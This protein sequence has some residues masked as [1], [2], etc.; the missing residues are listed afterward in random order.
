MFPEV[1]FGLPSLPSEPVVSEAMTKIL[2]AWRSRIKST[3]AVDRPEITPSLFAGYNDIISRIEDLARIVLS[4]GIVEKEEIE[5][6]KK[7]LD[8][9]TIDPLILFSEKVKARMGDAPGL[10]PILLRNHMRQEQ[11]AGFMDVS[12]SF[13]YEVENL[14]DSAEHFH[15]VEDTLQQTME[16]FDAVCYDRGTGDP[17]LGSDLLVQIP[18]GLLLMQQFAREVRGSLA[19]AYTTELHDQWELNVK[20]LIEDWAEAVEK[21]LKGELNVVGDLLKQDKN[22]AAI[23]L[24]ALK[25]QLIKI[26]ENIAR[27]MPAFP[28]ITFNSLVTLKT[29]VL[30]VAVARID[31]LTKLPK[32]NA[33]TIIPLGLSEN[34]PP[35]YGDDQ[36]KALVG[37]RPS[38]REGV[39]SNIKSFFSRLIPE[40]WKRS[41]ERTEQITRIALFSLMLSGDI[42]KMLTQIHGFHCY[43]DAVAKELQKREFASVPIDTVD[44]IDKEVRYI[45]NMAGRH[46]KQFGNRLLTR[47]PKA[48][49]LLTKLRYDIGTNPL[50]IQKADE[51]AEFHRLTR[52][53]HELPRS[54][55]Y[56][57]LEFPEWWSA[58][59]TDQETKVT[60]P[61]E[62]PFAKTHEMVN[63]TKADVAAGYWDVSAEAEPIIAGLGN[64][65]P[66]AHALR[67]G[68]YLPIQALRQEATEQL[69]LAEL[70]F[71]IEHSSI[72]IDA[73]TLLHIG[74]DLFGEKSTLEGHNPIRITP[75]LVDQVMG[76]LAALT[77]TGRC[78]DDSKALFCDQLFASQFAASREAKLSFF[79]SLETKLSIATELNIKLQGASAKEFCDAIK[80]QLEALKPEDPTFFSG[81]WKKHAIVYEIIKHNNG[82]MTFRFY[83]TGE[84]VNYFARTV[85]KGE[86]LYEPYIEIN[87]IPEEN[88]SNPIFWKALYELENGEF[89][90]PAYILANSILPSLGGTLY[91]GVISVEK[92]REAQRS[93]TCSYQ[94]L[95]SAVADKQP[96]APEAQHDIFVTE[97]KAL[98]DFNQQNKINYTKLSFDD[99]VNFNLVSKYA[100]AFAARLVEWTDKGHITPREQKYALNIV[101]G[102]QE[103]L[104]AALDKIKADE[105]V[106]SPLCDLTPDLL[107]SQYNGFPLSTRYLTPIASEKNTIS[108]ENAL[109]LAVQQWTPRGSALM[110]DMQQFLE[111]ISKKVGRDIQ[112]FQTRPSSKIS[113]QE[114]VNVHAGIKQIVLKIPLHETAFWGDLKAED[115]V[116]LMQAFRDLGQRFSD[117]LADLRRT[118]PNRAVELQPSDYLAVVKL[119][120]VA[121]KLSSEH[122]VALGF[123]HLNLYQKR[124]ETF[125]HAGSLF[126]SVADPSWAIEAS[127]LR[128]YWQAARPKDGSDGF[129]QLSAKPMS[130]CDYTPVLIGKIE[131]AL[132]CD[133]REFTWILEQLQKS[134]IQG[135]INEKY[136]GSSFAQKSILEQAIE[137]YTGLYI[138][139]PRKNFKTIIP[140]SFRQVVELSYLADTLPA[141]DFG[142][143]ST[144]E[145][146]LFQRSV[147]SLGTAL[148]RYLNKSPNIP[149][150]GSR[151]DSPPWDEAYFRRT[152]PKIGMNV[153]SFFT[154]ALEYPGVV[155]RRVLPPNQVVVATPDTLMLPIGAQK[156]LDVQG[157]QQRLGMNSVMSLQIEETLGFFVENPSLL[158]IADN[159]LLFK[160]FFLDAGLLID[161]MRTPERL[162]TF[163]ACFNQFCNHHYR[164]N[165]DI[166]RYDIALFYLEISQLLCHSLE[167]WQKYSQKNFEV[168]DIATKGFLHIDKECQALSASKSLLKFAPNQRRQLEYQ[169]HRLLVHHYAAIEPMTEDSLT[170]LL[171]QKIHLSLYYDDEMPPEAAVDLRTRDVLQTRLETIQTLLHKPQQRNFILNAVWNHFSP[172]SPVIEWTQDGFPDFSSADKRNFIH[173]AEGTITSFDS[174]VSLIPP[175]IANH[176]EFK[177]HFLSLVQIPEETLKRFFPE[178][179]Q[180]RFYIEHLKG[181]RI[182]NAIRIGRDSFEFADEAHNRYRVKK[183]GEG[184]IFERQFSQEWCRQSLDRDEGFS[185]FFVDEKTMI[186]KAPNRNEKGEYVYY[187]TDKLTRVPQYEV[188]MQKNKW[189]DRIDFTVIHQ[190]DPSSQRTGL[191]VAN[192][193]KC[194]FASSLG[195]F[196]NPAHIIVLQELAT[197]VIKSLEFPRYGLSFK[198][199]KDPETKQWVAESPQYPGYAVAEVQRVPALRELDHYLVLKK[200]PAEGVLTRLVLIPDVPFKTFDPEKDSTLEPIQNIHEASRQGT[201]IEGLTFRDITPVYDYAVDPSTGQLNP[202]KNVEAGRLVLALNSLWK[203]KYGAAARQLDRIPLIRPLTKKEGVLLL[204]IVQMHMANNDPDLESHAVRLKALALFLRSAPPDLRATLNQDEDFTKNT[205]ASYFFYANTSRK[206]LGEKQ[207]L[208]MP[209][210]EIGLLHWL[211]KQAKNREL[212]FKFSNTQ[213]EVLSYRKQLLGMQ[214]NKEW[215]APP[216]TQGPTERSQIIRSFKNAWTRDDFKVS[217]RDS[218]LSSEI[219]DLEA[220]YAAFRNF[221]SLRE[222]EIHNIIYQISGVSIDWQTMPRERLVETLRSVLMM[223]FN[224]HPNPHDVSPPILILLGLIEDASR[225][226]SAKAFSY[227][228]QEN[229]AHLDEHNLINSLAEA[230]ADVVTGK[231]GKF[232]PLPWDTEPSVLEMGLQATSVQAPVAG[233]CI[234]LR[235]L[236]FDQRFPFVRTHDLDRYFD[237]G[238]VVDVVPSTTTATELLAV[239]QPATTVDRITARELK[240]VRDLVSK[241][242]P[243]SIEPKYTVKELGIPLRDFRFKLGDDIAFESGELMAKGAK[244]LEMANQLPAD[245]QAATDLQTRWAADLKS[246]IDLD[247]LFRLFLRGDT[248]GYQQRNPALT[249]DK[250]AALANEVKAYLEQATYRQHLVRLS[251]SVAALETEMAHGVP[252][253]ELQPRIQEVRTLALTRRHFSVKVH[254]EYLVFEYYMNLLMRKSQVENL[255]KL[256]IKDGKI[257]AAQYLGAVL[258]MDMGGGKT[259]VLLPLLGLLHADGKH[260]AIGVLPDALIPSMSSELYMTSKGSFDQALEVL[261]FDRDVDLNAESLELLRQQLVHIQKDRK[262][263]L[264]GSGSVQSLYLKWIE[265]TELYTAHTRKIASA[266][267]IG[268]IVLKDTYKVQVEQELKLFREIFAL[269][270]KA[271]I[272]MIDEVDTVLNVLKS[273]HYTIGEAKG[274]EKLFADVISDVYAFLADSEDINQNISLGFTHFT[275]EKPFTK[276]QHDSI[277][278]PALVDALFEGKLGRKIVG[279]PEFMATMNQD[280]NKAQKESVTA[281]L[282]GN[283]SKD[284]DDFIR[285]KVAPDI[286]DALT[287]YRQEISELLPL[288]LSRNLNE[289]YGRDPVRPSSYLALPYD[290]STPSLRAQFGTEMEETNYAMQ[291]NWADFPQDIVR[292]ELNHLADLVN[293]ERRRKPGIDFKTLLIYKKNFLEELAGGDPSYDLFNVTPEQLKTMTERVDANS[294][295]KMKLINRYVL[296]Q[297]RVYERQLNAD[298]QIFRLLFHITMGMTGTTQNLD[299]FP[300]EMR[301]NFH[302]SDTTEKSLDILWRMSSKDPCQTL[303]TPKSP[304]QDSQYVTELVNSIFGNKKS[305]ARSIIDT[306]GLFRDV[307]DRAD[308]AEAMLHALQSDP[309]IQGVAFY[310][311]SN[312]LMVMTLIDGKR[313]VV[314]LS[315]SSLKRQQIAA[316]WDQQHT[317]GSDIRVSLTMCA[318]VTIGRY[319]TLRDLLQS[320]WRLRGLATGQRVEFVVSQEERDLI[321]DVLKKKMGISIGEDENLKF[322]HI[323]LYSINTG[324]ERQGTDNYRAF[325]QKL[326]AYLLEK[327]LTVM[328]D[329][330]TPI[331]KLGEFYHAAEALFATTH[332]IRPYFLYGARKEPL[333]RE[334]ALK[335]D[336]DAFI[337]SPA[338]QLFATDPLLSE[339]FSTKALK[340]GLDALGKE[341]L[342]R[343]PEEVVKSAYGLEQEKEAEKE[344]ETKTEKEDVRSVF[345][346][347][348]GRPRPVIVWERNGLFTEAYFNLTRVDSILRRDYEIKART[349]LH[350]IVGLSDVLNHYDGL[351]EFKDVF[352]S[353]LTC[354][355]NMCPV[356]SSDIDVRAYEPFGYYQQQLSYVLAKE[357]K[358]GL[359]LMLLDQNDADAFKHMLENDSIAPLKG[360]AKEVRLKLYHLSTGV[361]TQGQESL[362]PQAE[363]E[364]NKLAV[365]AKFFRGVSRYEGKEKEYLEQWVKAHGVEKMHQ[366]FTEKVLLWN[367]VSQFY[368]YNSPL[369]NILEPSTESTP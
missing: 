331:E 17:L 361:T 163:V 6:L 124:F 173:I 79:E 234:Y 250:A 192:M 2:G 68:Q 19:E 98:Y 47:Y 117:N 262:V 217:A 22:G 89:K 324:A 368:Y 151:Y 104:R 333:K 14:V 299:T 42:S 314:D 300:K 276:E 142:K 223:K 341:E 96:S 128:R 249:P 277:V 130:T 50:S 268:E 180:R 175:S 141:S 177:H 266:A 275:A 58:F 77:K 251:E 355:L 15:L 196:E 27:N 7:E 284:D 48:E 194:P 188:T 193:K 247:E 346:P 134:D 232:A 126:F 70:T 318:A 23:Q 198:V 303:K 281:F 3:Y 229:L 133:V 146:T 257:G 307:K 236:P 129:F 336:I 334:E 291:L 101:Q 145:Y 144:T 139:S 367:K 165:I 100:E 154:G 364:F 208:F 252:N 13:L 112:T 85:V 293:E 122:A 213:L 255:N 256:E 274:L 295:V 328:L 121:D 327:L 135:V 190:L 203:Q 20:W 315:Q 289:H 239:L 25:E 109:P 224:L 21:K 49:M 181:N 272:A 182:F 84:G 114:L 316:F 35:A 9:D 12:R 246:P 51:A 52:M 259:S 152:S 245:K 265:K 358:E 178:E 183:E 24:L 214:S 273:T 53:F 351:K 359:Q 69:R 149:I 168:S 120:T 61:D 216:M 113:N 137:V 161:E 267:A 325:Q 197:G 119:L 39:Y 56:R 86:V 97:L 138:D 323:L 115:A 215:I 29:K 343:M 270:K 357:G 36:W 292:K 4:G 261:K 294:A 271:G 118:N 116:P 150:H 319:T 353:R 174:A 366:L 347:N 344:K 312:Q 57:H 166:G 283:P 73:K 158:E 286:Q 220:M 59:T 108:E 31:E 228:N 43:G 335:G 33:E 88:L 202:L 221:P 143:D 82:Q 187:L 140:P 350:P 264:M 305:S 80:E 75:Y 207:S 279:L 212:K 102:I 237:K 111:T 209:I 65:K 184:L 155:P 337:Q 72:P 153:S 131:W 26:R 18:Q 91:Q 269:L 290:H 317:T 320:V 172:D 179:D 233:R 132:D 189:V 16:E 287:V 309:T 306:A 342:D 107:S 304:K 254:P 210:E 5:D 164:D 301:H 32:D 159:R 218:I 37:K 170:Q 63:L 363:E 211:E 78:T 310:D 156:D 340:Q 354:S 40:R 338:F 11:K 1:P 38:P 313:S 41:E 332:N 171:I 230:A 71:F 238:K 74:G 105:L 64:I 60:T 302:P 167:A 83:S 54:S 176:I 46:A 240:R 243:P 330:T 326:S 278:K 296:P 365:Q 339:K 226:P 263:L 201:L 162:E 222:W 258:Q 345:E 191:V 157:L 186:W 282:G 356:V 285:D 160:M 92:L 62:M 225:F 244:I 231:T 369:Q 349:D 10:E 66:T 106:A 110:N 241:M 185:P 169:L 227:L 127:E 99:R 8:Q 147:S 67:N 280:G 253:E 352:D 30:D 348:P 206:Y 311:K 94:S 136:Q 199:R 235:E 76:K 360:E 123:D 195:A 204:K 297:I 103:H 288:T 45:K 28:E 34:K 242:P 260:M 87:K 90:I 81:G 125:L 362:S 55:P 95:V 308:V 200:H 93:G 321:K 44:Q 148:Y 205:A 322:E 219:P 298:A 248:A 329:E